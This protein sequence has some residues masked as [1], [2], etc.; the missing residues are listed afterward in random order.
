MIAF[1][2]TNKAHIETFETLVRQHN[3][4]IKTEHYVNKEILNNALLSGKT[5]THQF[6]KEIEAIRKEKP[7]LIICTCS[8]YGSESDKFTD[9]YRIDKPIIEYMV[10]NYSKIG[11]VYTANSTKTVSED[12]MLEIAA[13]QNKLIEVVYCDCSEY[14]SF[15]EAGDFESYEKGI[16]ENIKQM[17]SQVDVFFLAQAS[18]AGAKKNLKSFEREVFTSPEYGIKTLLKKI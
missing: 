6:T 7:S 5:D 12:L 2:H 15:F 16:A 9:V 1:L 14:W 17:A 10:T 4:E 13:K 8:T 3:P 18:M 11:L